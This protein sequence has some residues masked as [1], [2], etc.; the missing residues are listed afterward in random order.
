MQFDKIES[1]FFNDLTL[2]FECDSF[3]QAAASAEDLKWM[4]IMG[5]HGEYKLNANDPAVERVRR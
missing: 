3:A 1:I 4:K 2:F 5:D